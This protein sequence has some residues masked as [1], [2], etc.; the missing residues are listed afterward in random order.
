MPARK[1]AVDLDP[2]QIVVVTVEKE[3]VDLNVAWM[4]DGV[5]SFGFTDKA[6]AEAEYAKQAKIKPKQATIVC[7]AHLFGGGRVKVWEAKASGFKYR[8]WAKECEDDW[9]KWPD[10]VIAALDVPV[11]SKATKKA[12]KKVIGEIIPQ[13]RIKRSEVMKRI[14][15][16]AAAKRKPA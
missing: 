14:E 2:Y 4:I 13:K 16:R 12:A 8:L 3:I 9:K 6:E 10:G 11:P 5:Q 1:D 15:E 7:F